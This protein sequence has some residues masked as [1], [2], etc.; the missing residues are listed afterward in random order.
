MKSKRVLAPV[1]RFTEILF[2]LIMVL[3]FTCALSV[4]ESGREDVRAMLIGALGCNIAWGIIDAAFYLISRASE[5]ARN[6]HLLREL[7]TAKSLDETRAIIAEALPPRVA[8][9]MDTADLD[10]LGYRLKDLP[11]TV[12]HPRLVGED[13]KG[14]FGVFLLVF[15]STLPVVAPFVFVHD[16]H[17]AMRISNGIAIVLLFAAGH[18]LARYSGM[19]PFLTGVT[20]VL[21]GVGLVSLAMAL[22]G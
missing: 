4:A 20:M 15:L 16:A 9:V 5:K 8:E 7:L 21:V 14:A 2:G 1:E 17:L 13:W 6:S 12:E 19:R 10:R 11:V 18:M 22:G 3:T